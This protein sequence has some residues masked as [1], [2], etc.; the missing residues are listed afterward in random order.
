MIFL[1]KWYQPHFILLHS[2]HSC[3][4]PSEKLVKGKLSGDDVLLCYWHAR[5]KAGPRREDLW[6]IRVI[7]LVL[8]S[9]LRIPSRV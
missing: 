2:E 3:S 4:S 6:Q 1:H 9:F 5:E 8:A 7:V